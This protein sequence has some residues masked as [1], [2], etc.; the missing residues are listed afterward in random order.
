MP[1][2]RVAAECGLD[3]DLLAAADARIDRPYAVVRH[4]LLCHEHHPGGPGQADEATEVF[5]V[6]K[7]LGATVAGA[8]AYRTRDLPRTGRKTGALSDE[9]RVDHWLDAFS[10]HPD[11][12]LAHV[13][14]MLAHNEDLSFGARSFLYDA[15]GTIQINRLSDVLN[16]AIAQDPERLGRDLEEFTRRFVFE[17]LG[18]RHSRWS[19]G[20]PDKVFAY[21]WE[22]SVRDM[23]RLGLLLVHGGRWNGEQVL[24]AEWVSRMTHPAFE[25]ANTGYG[26]LTWLNASWGYTF[27]IRK[28]ETQLDPCAP[29]AVNRVFPH[30]LSEATDCGYQPP[31]DCEQQ[32]DAGVWYAHGLFGQYIVGHRGLDLVLAVK[33]F[34][35]LDG[36]RRLW[37]AV[38]PA[39]V[40]L[41]PEF[42]GDEAAFCARYGDNAYAPDL[43]AAG[44]R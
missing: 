17:P 2:E 6:T 38:R 35:D 16:A 27:S 37:D 43:P 12:R 8:V 1:R 44:R 24:S 22:A 5:S 42:R 40:A 20:R 25:D 13:L 7:T 28:L 36:P 19:G 11:A 23:V 18:M 41:D 14:A 4:G 9:D 26:Y 10:F 32:F 29:V 39:L 33:D 15:S 3:P 21:S 30:G 34:G 31:Y